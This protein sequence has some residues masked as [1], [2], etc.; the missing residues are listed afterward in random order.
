MVIRE[1]KCEQITNS[2]LEDKFHETSLEAR[3][4]DKKTSGLAR[5]YFKE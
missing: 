3:I 1:S 5:S 2:I 4:Q